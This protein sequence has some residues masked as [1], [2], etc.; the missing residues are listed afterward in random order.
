MKGRALRITSC[1][2]PL[3]WYAGLVGQVVPLVREEADCYWSREPAGFVNIVRKEDAELIEAGTDR[4]DEKGK[5]TLVQMRKSTKGNHMK[6][7][8]RLYCADDTGQVLVTIESGDEGPELQISFRMK[9]GRCSVKLGFPDNDSGWDL[10]HKAL[11]EMTEETA[12]NLA[13]EQQQRGV[14][15]GLGAEG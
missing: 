6:D 15:A 7:F 5:S 3:M 4:C 10:A 12:L 8:A 2:D 13:R 9:V 11:D 14:F 1:R